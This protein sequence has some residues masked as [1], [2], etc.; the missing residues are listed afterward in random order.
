MICLCRR[1]GARRASGTR[2]TSPFLF[3]IGLA[4]FV[5]VFARLSLLLVLLWVLWEVFATVFLCQMVIF[6]QLVRI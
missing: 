3:C 6:P 5:P 2:L 4:Y 1:F